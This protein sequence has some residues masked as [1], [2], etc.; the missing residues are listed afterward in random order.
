MK[1]RVKK[2]LVRRRLTWAGHVKGMGD[3][4]LSEGADAQN[5]KEKR[6]RER[7]KLRWRIA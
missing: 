1:E 3:E 5:V 7:P 6:K 4:K 2:K